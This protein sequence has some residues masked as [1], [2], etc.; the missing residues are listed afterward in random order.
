MATFDLDGW[1]ARSGA[2][3]LT[4]IDWAEVPRHPV[5]PDAVRPPHYTQHVESH[6]IASL[7]ALLATR[8]VDDPEVPTFLA[9]WLYEETF[10]GIAPARFLEASGHPVPPRPRPHG[11]ESLAQWLEARAT[12]LLSRAWSA[13]C[14]VPMT[15]GAVNGPPHLPR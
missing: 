11:Q 2:L 3:D 12:A 5:P 8:A 6:P 7:R 13:F 1:V 14:A 15:W 9:C 4:G 10:H